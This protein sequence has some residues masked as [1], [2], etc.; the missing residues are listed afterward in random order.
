MVNTSDITICRPYLGL[1]FHSERKD[2][3]NTTS[4]RPT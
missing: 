1:R 2:G 4:I 3:T